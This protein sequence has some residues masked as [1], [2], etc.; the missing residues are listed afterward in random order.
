[1]EDLQGPVFGVTPIGLCIFETSIVVFDVTT[2]ELTHTVMPLI[3]LLTDGHPLRQY[4][5][6][7]VHSETITDFNGRLTGM[8]CHLN[9][10]A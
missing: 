8:G 7:P 2:S 1:M 9:C 10:R 3:L 4:S 6:D 5:N